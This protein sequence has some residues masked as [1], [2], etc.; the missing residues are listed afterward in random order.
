MRN[1]HGNAHG[2]AGEGWD[3]TGAPSTYLEQGRTEAAGGR[4][5]WPE[6]ERDWQADVDGSRSRDSQADSVSDWSCGDS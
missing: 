1:W 3:V 2:Q 6:A 5:S 4:S